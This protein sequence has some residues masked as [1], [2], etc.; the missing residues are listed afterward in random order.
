MD[1]A[2]SRILRTK[3]IMGIFETPYQAAPQN[4][5]KKIIHSDKSVALARRLDRESIVLLENNG[6][7]PLDKKALKSV[8]VIGPMAHGFMNV[9]CYSFGIREIIIDICFS[10]VIMSCINRNTVASLPWTE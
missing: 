7:L 1:T 6:V 5:W 8:A 10:T 3:F 9:S 2:V 4:Q